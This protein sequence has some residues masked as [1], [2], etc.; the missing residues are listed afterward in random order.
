[1]LRW[2]KGERE[3]RLKRLFDFDHYFENPE[4]N[5]IKDC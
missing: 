2:N 4:K 3:N 1:M 5:K